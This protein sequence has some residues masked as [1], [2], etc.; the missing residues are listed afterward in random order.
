MKYQIHTVGLLTLFGI[1]SANAVICVIFSIL[2]QLIASL[3]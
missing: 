1:F 2:Y 3:T